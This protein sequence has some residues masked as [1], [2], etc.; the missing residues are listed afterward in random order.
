L[1]WEPAS[2]ST[3]LIFSPSLPAILAVECFA[4]EDVVAFVR[5]E[6]KLSVK[7]L[8]S[9]SQGEVIKDVFLKNRAEIGIV[10]EDPGKTHHRLRDEMQVVSSTVDIEVRRRDGRH[11]IIIKPE[12]EECFLRSMK[13]VGVDSKL[14]SNAGDL[15]AILN[16]GGDAKHETFREELALLHR[17]SRKKKMASFVTDLEDVLRSG[18]CE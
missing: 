11:L 16:I 12:L 5:D 15:Q 14:P 3:W 6:L 8:H 13:R 1:T 10:D 4:D 17:T 9:F 2:S 18:I 7:R